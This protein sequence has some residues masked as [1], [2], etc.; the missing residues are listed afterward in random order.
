M[1]VIFVGLMAFRAGARDDQRVADFDELGRALR[2]YHLQ[3]HSYPADLDELVGATAGLP[4]VPDDPLAPGRHYQYAVSE[5]RQNYVL[6]ATL[7]DG[8]S[9]KLKNDTDGMVY[10]LN[11]DDRPDYNYCLRSF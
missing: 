3:F 2:L 10:N 8:V 4:A 9:P 5:D 6:L 7:E 11:C 1:L